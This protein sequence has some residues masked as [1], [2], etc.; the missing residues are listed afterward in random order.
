L[1]EVGLRGALIRIADLGRLAILGAKASDDLFVQHLN[2]LS[3]TRPYST[4]FRYLGAQ[5]KKEVN[6]FAA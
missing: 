2:F 5:P 4:F 3:N 6:T 1:P